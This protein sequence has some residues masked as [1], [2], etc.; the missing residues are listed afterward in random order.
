[1]STP[2]HSP[3]SAV[4]LLHIA[5]EIPIAL[6]GIYSPGALPFIQLNNTAVVFLKLYASLVLATCIASLLC[7]GLPEFLPGKRALALSLCVYHTICSTVLY[8]APR[9]IPYSFGVFMEGYR[10]TPE[11][12][13]GTL[14]G[15]V[16]LALVFWWQATLPYTAMARS[17]QNGGK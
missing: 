2:G 3:L 14:H 12:V 6:Q 7:F 11:N 4:F 13:W 16:G 10:V 5:L 15:I 8:N 1:M 9:F 17:I